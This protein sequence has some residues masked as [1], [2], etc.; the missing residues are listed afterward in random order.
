MSDV[1]PTPEQLREAARRFGT[2]PDA[3]RDL[4][5]FENFVY[6]YDDAN[7]EG[8]VLRLVHDSHR[9][10]RQVRGEL[11]WLRFLAEGGLSV[12]P[13]VP[14]R[15]GDLVEELAG[16]QGAFFAS[17]F[18]RIEGE[19]LTN[20]RVTPELTRA[21]GRLLAEIHE[22]SASYVP[23]DPGARPT[24]LTEPYVADRYRHAHRVEPEI[25]TRFD[26]VVARLEAVPE[27]SAPF[28]MVHNDAH[29]GNF[30]V[31]GGRI[32]LFDFD[33]CMH[34]FLVAD[35]AMAIYYASWAAGDDREGFARAFVP[36]LLAGYREV[37]DL[38]PDELRLVPDLLKLREVDLYVLVH[39]KWDMTNLTDVR[40]KMLASYRESI[41]TEA[42]FIDVDFTSF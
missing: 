6:A 12:A 17:S 1:S 27:G 38:G 32:V 29:P 7:Q 39:W 9:S 25:M 41:L 14:S 31:Q 28:G 35:L 36:H 5:S 33:D 37:R 13:P 4:G 26:E 11:H 16:D 20:D 22:R 30:L 10:A 2:S 42:P 24:W 23:E 19:K 34:N 3:L 40:R 21:W 8:R 18:V 15:G